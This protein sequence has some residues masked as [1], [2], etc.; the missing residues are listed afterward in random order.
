MHA[1][2]SCC[3]QLF[4]KQKKLHERKFRNK[5]HYEKFYRYLIQSS[6]C[7]FEKLCRMLPDKIC[8]KMESLGEEEVAV[9]FREAWGGE[10]GTWMNGFPGSTTSFRIDTKL[11]RN[12][13]QDGQSTGLKLVER[14][15]RAGINH[16]FN[17]VLVQSVQKTL[18]Y[19]ED[20]LR[21]HFEVP[22][23]AASL[24]ANFS[25]SI[26]MIF[27]KGDFPERGGGGGGV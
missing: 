18:E 25:F 15:F 19:P 21:R 14:R 4:R 10:N 6:H 12:F 9:W 20:T 22:S 24:P 1:L 17:A 13:S 5:D 2:H 8:A 7:P 11:S 26:S 3:V 23:P 16:R 27:Q